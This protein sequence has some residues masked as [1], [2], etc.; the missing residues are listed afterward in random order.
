[1]CPSRFHQYSYRRAENSYA[2]S[3]QASYYLLN[4]FSSFSSFSNLF[5][6]FDRRPSPIFFHR[7]INII[8][9]I[10]MC[11]TCKSLQASAQT[12]FGRFRYLPAANGCAAVWVQFTQL[13]L[14]HPIDGSNHTSNFVMIYRCMSAQTTFERLRYQLSEMIVTIKRV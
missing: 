14:Y 8:P 11:E 9:W 4:R 6:A 13:F 7:S 10:S 3:Y 5:L 2:N 1:M 12:S